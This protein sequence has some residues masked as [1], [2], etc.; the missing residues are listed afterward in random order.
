MNPSS[1]MNRFNNIINDNHISV[2]YINY[3]NSS[4]DTFNNIISIIRQQDI[5]MQSILLNSINRPSTQRIRSRYGTRHIDDNY[6][7]A[8]YSTYNQNTT[9]RTTFSDS[10]ARERPRRWWNNTNSARDILNNTTTARNP[11]NPTNSTNSTNSTTSD[12]GNAVADALSLFSLGTTISSQRNSFRPTQQQIQEA[13]EEISFN[14]IVN[15]SN[16]TCP[17]THE[18]FSQNDSV[19]RIRHCQHIFTPNALRRWFETS[20]RCPMCRY[21]I[22][23]QTE[24]AVTQEQ[25]ATSQAQSATSQ[26]Q[27]ATTQAQ[28]ENT[29]VS[30]RTLRTT[31]TNQTDFM[32]NLSSIITNDLLN[33]LN[34]NGYDPSNNMVFEYALLNTNA[35]TD[36]TIDTSANATADTS[37][38]ATAD[39][40]ANID[41][42]QNNSTNINDQ[43]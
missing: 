14:T 34:S 29:S 17:I 38:N 12:W 4:R 9:T 40:S 36:A 2:D 6:S 5:A 25:S 35:E 33:Q 3:V 8:P 31:F 41:I 42:F 7:D 26:E 18:P 39:A 21:N 20:P 19:T 11:T 23:S 22:T 37:A 32:N 30:Q 15:P 43:I 28:S 13:T 27:S 16:T 10:R 24:N 1:N